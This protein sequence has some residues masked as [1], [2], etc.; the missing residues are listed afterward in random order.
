MAGNTV[1]LEFAGDA[2]KLQKAAKESVKA[3]DQ[4]GDAAKDAGDAFKHTGDQGADFTGKIGKLGAGVEG[5]SGAFDTASEGLSAFA[6]LQNQSADRASEQKRKLLELNQAQEDYNQAVRDGAQAEIDADQAAVDLDQ[7]RLDQTTALKAY[8]TAVK[9][10]GRNSAEAR[11]A[12]IDLKQAGVDVRQAQ[13]DAAQA[14]R[15]GAQAAIDAKTAT[16]DLSDAQRALQ[17]TDLG[18]FADQAARYA[19]LLSA[20]VAVTGLVTGA[21]WAW[22][23]AQLANPIGLIIAA[24]A[25]LV[26][27]IVIIATKTDWFQKLWRAAWGGIKDA[28]QAVGSWFKDTLWEKWIKGAFDAIVGKAASVVN[29]FRDLPGRIK[30]AVSAVN[31]VIFSPFR[32]A[33]NRI[34]DAWNNT[35]GRLNWTVPGW[36][37]GIGGQSIGAPHLPRFH[38]G[39]TVPGLP[40]QEVPIMAMAGEQ[41]VQPGAAAGGGSV[42]V[43]G[44]ALID[45]VIDLI[46]EQVRR[47]GG[48]PGRLGI[49]LPRGAG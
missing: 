26:A 21:Q 45:Q 22:N 7:A 16:Q 15:D 42:Y 17:P 36:V 32:A 27:V 30:S 24:V 48:D 4:V 37:P 34:A 49:T 28:A 13:E 2:D 31:T 6:D 3:T 47:S 46:A 14:T 43:R 1:T 19:P 39:G 29:W 33:F 18:K 9:E 40:G 11:Q 25:A 35:I 12:E 10:H 38:G 8:N 44:D 5:L 23:A 41:V 20:L